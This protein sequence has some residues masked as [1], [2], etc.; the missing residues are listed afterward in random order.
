MS[1]LYQRQLDIFN[2]DRTESQV[3][4]TIVG[5]GSIG[6]WV[7]LGLAKLGLQSVTVW[8]FD[9]VEMHN[10]PNQIYSPRDNGKFKV[11]A[12]TEIVEDLTG[13]KIE[14]YPKKFPPSEYNLDYSKYQR[15]LIIS[16][17]DSMESREMIW[18]WLKDKN[19]EEY[20]HQLIDGRMGGEN[21]SVYAVRS[22]A[23]PKAYENTLYSDDTSGIKND[24]L[25]E[26]SEVPCT[27]RGI[28]DVSLFISSV[29]VNLTRR[30]L[31]DMGVPFATI[32]NI[33]GHEVFRY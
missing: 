10:S 18:S 3:G 6:S 9:K 12:L 13:L 14:A 1:E 22:L 20:V 23:S 32:A 19:T 8:D 16:A 24:R 26:L 30:M 21:I 31:Y 2:P 27:A 11:E 5:A 28:I 17:V 29:I 7:T 15:H 25:R 33:T 4:I